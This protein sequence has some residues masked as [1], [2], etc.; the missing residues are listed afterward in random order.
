MYASI[1]SMIGWAIP[2]GLLAFIWFG[3]MGGLEADSDFLRNALT[4]RGD[5]RNI[6]GADGVVFLGVA[7]AAIASVYAFYHAIKGL[8]RGSESRA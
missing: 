7:F 4:F 8:F 1:K 5:I 6:W 3:A 2:V